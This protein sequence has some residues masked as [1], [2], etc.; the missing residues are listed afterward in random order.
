[1]GYDTY[2]RDIHYSLDFLTW[3][4]RAYLRRMLSYHPSCLVLPKDHL[5]SFCQRAKDGVNEMPPQVLPDR[6]E[7]GVVKLDLYHMLLQKRT[8]E[9][10]CF[11]AM[12]HW[13]VPFQRQQQ[14]TKGSKHAHTHTKGYKYKCSQPCLDR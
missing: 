9:S 7:L 3:H 11:K 8:H 4:V 5:H 1:M 10:S 12:L 2:C 13:Y 6:Y 14:H